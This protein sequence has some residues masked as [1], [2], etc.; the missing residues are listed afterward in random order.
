MLYPLQ[1][2][3]E[4]PFALLSRRVTPLARVPSAS[5]AGSNDAKTARSRLRRTALP[6]ITH[7]LV[8]LGSN[9]MTIFSWDIIGGDGTLE[10]AVRAS[11]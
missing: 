6:F 10:Y 3:L 8:F 11:A 1:L 4:H 9:G 5:A 7:H 2:L